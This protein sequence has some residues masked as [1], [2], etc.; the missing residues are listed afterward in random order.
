MVPSS[1]WCLSKWRCGWPN[2][3]LPRGVVDV[4]ELLDQDVAG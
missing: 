3:G 1:G 4:N 2:L